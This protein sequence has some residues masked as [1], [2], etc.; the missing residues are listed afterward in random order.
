D[1][2]LERHG[3]RVETGAQVGRRRR[4][5]SAHQLRLLGTTGRVR[6]SR[7]MLNRVY[8]TPRGGDGR[9]RIPA[10]G[11]TDGAGR[12]DARGGWWGGGDDTRVAWGGPPDGAPRRSG[13]V[14]QS[15]GI[16]R[17]L[18]RAAWDGASTRRPRR[19]NPGALGRARAGRRRSRR[20]EGGA[21]ANAAAAPAGAEPRLGAGWGR[22]RP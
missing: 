4:G 20:A 2:Q 16:R 1:V 10:G 15:R 14:R 5:S 3:Q 21:S 7:M 9:A 6:G 11:R 18:Q 8:V 19:A 22:T 13:A 17:S 12:G